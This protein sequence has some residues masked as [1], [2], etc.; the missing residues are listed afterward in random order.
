[1][2]KV[3]NVLLAIIFL[4]GGVIVGLYFGINIG[5]SKVKCTKCPKTKIVE[6]CKEKEKS[7][8]TKEKT[9]TTISTDSKKLNSYTLTNTFGDGE[10]TKTVKAYTLTTLSGFAGATSN[11]FY[12]DEDYNLHYLE[13]ANLDD[14]IIATNIKDLKLIDDELVAYKSDNTEI[15]ED[16]QFVNYE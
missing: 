12:I 4:L 9:S 5:K 11:V 3:L 13:L 16:N 1:M 7:N 6:K 2:K 10:K 8:D 14:K 15:K